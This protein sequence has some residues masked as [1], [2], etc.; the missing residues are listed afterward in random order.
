MN[1]EGICTASDCDYRTRGLKTH[2]T[3]AVVSE[4][5]KTSGAFVGR[6]FYY[7][8]L[9]RVIQVVERNVHAASAVTA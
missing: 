2:E 6:W 5:M 9:G 1:V 7:D 3:L 4:G 8:R